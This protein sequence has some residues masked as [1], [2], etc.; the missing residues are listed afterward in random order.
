MLVIFFNP[1]FFQQ[2]CLPQCLTHFK[3]CLKICICKGKFKNKYCRNGSGWR[4]LDQWVP[5]LGVHDIK[6]YF[7]QLTPSILFQPIL[8]L[9]ECGLFCFLSLWNILR[10]KIQDK[11]FDIVVIMWIS[12]GRQKRDFSI[13]EVRIHWLGSNTVQ[14]TRN[15]V[16]LRIQCNPN[17]SWRWKDWLYH[18]SSLTRTSLQGVGVPLKQG[19][20]S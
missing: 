20:H 5:L 8:F 4:L 17:G 19:W 10:L 16:T 7:L 2:P 11:L 15:V 13:G 9:Y 18:Q 12:S 1:R 6:N 3:W 14:E